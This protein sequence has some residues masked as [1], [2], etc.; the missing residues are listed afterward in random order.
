[1]KKSILVLLVG[2]TGLASHAQSVVTYAG[3]ANDDPTNNY[4]STSNKDL[5]DTY[6]AF[7]AGICFDPSGRMYTAEKNKVRIIVADK[8]YIRA[9]SLQAT[10]FSEGY[11]N[12]TGTSATFRDPGGLACNSN[13]EIFV[14]DI[15][16]HCIRKIASYQNLGNGQ[17]VSTFAGSNPTPGLPGYGTS[18]S[19]DGT[20]TAARFN[21]PTDIAIDAAGNL[22][23]TEYDNFTIRKITS[24]GVVTTLAGTAGSDGNTDA[25]GAEARF[26]GPYGV[27]IYN[28]NTIVVTDPWNT[29]IRLV[30]IFSGATTTL[31]GSTTG[32]DPRQIDGTLAEARFKAPKGVAV[33]QGIIYVADQNVIRAIDVAGNSVTTFAGNKSE[34]GVVDG[35]GTAASFTEINHIE[36]D[37]NGNL[38]VSE[39]SAAVAS[40]V[41]RKVTI[42]ALAPSANFEATKRNLLVNEETTL[43]DISGG[44][45]ASSRTWTVAPGTYTIKSGD[46]TT[47]S[48]T[49]SFSATGFYNVTLA[50]TNDFGNNTKNVESFFAVST[51][52]G[53]SIKEYSASNLASLYPNP[54]SNMVQIVLDP[55]ISLSNISVSL[56]DINAKLVKE[57]DPLKPFSTLD[58]PNGTYYVTIVNEKI[59]IA[60]K[61]IVTHR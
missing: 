38:Y 30:N 61:L 13:G 2:F 44:Q 7:P 42:S 21:K 35:S 11:K 31:T 26:G 33:V 19:T 29:N 22:Y 59:S 25:T 1:M 10:S 53:G 15:E 46:L 60:K 56:Y 52:Q 32:A 16:N 6:F 43:T 14:A 34:F 48:F 4:E 18:G 58:L 8:L 37:D 3:I 41:I 49:T 45:E 23:V 55:S 40:H 50:I 54:T 47:K 28:S 9:G 20:G 51:T 12:A 36:A 5:D 39:N 57:I 24:A 17:V 27:A